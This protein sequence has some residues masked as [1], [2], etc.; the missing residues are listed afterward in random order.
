[1]TEASPSPPDSRSPGPMPTFGSA[2]YQ[3]SG[4]RSTLTTI[5]CGPNLRC[6]GSIASI[7]QQS[8]GSSRAG[9][10]RGSGPACSVRVPPYRDQDVDDLAVRV[11]SSVHVAPDAVDLD[12]G[13]V[14]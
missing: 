6:P 5:Y 14:H 10:A 2:S 12:V 11:D 8:T 4:S 9:R 7:R 3:P 13:L 1:M